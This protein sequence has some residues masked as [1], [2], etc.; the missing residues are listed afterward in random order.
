MGISQYNFLVISCTVASNIY[1]RHVRKLT[2]QLNAVRSELCNLFFFYL[3][4]LDHIFKT[5][6]G[7]SNSRLFVSYTY[8]GSQPDID[9]SYGICLNSTRS[10]SCNFTVFVQ[11]IINLI[12]YLS[13][14]HLMFDACKAN[15]I[16]NPT[17]QSMPTKI[18]R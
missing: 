6:T 8:K 18:Q 16:N 5:S 13:Y 2:V 15:S 11:T 4:R 14:T 3:L 10:L 1:T 12:K 17:K 7:N 9:L